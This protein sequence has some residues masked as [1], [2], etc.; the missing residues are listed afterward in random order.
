[1]SGDGPITLSVLLWARPGA[2]DRLVG[3]EDQVLRLVADHG[4]DVL[5]RARSRSG[6]LGPDQP[7][8][9][10]LIRF[11]SRAALERYRGDDR[12]AAL[13]ALR[14]AAVARTEVVEV[15]IVDP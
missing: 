8:E 13:G 14:E 10:H 1:M 2:E 7:Y 5:Y 4:G 12:R 9:V 6:S 15:D 3:Y 11:P